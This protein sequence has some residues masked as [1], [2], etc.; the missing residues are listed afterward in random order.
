MNLTPQ[1]IIDV[2][3]PGNLQGRLSDLHA[4]RD[5]VEIFTGKIQGE[6]TFLHRRG[7]PG[8]DKEKVLSLHSTVD[9]PLGMLLQQGPY[10]HIPFQNAL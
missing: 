7:D 1:P 9:S 5:D 10:F 3:V 2:Q 8:P 6:I 4:G